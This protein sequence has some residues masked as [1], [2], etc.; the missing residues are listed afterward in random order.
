LS[1][2][3]RYGTGFSNYKKNPYQAIRQLHPAN[4]FAHFPDDI[5]NMPFSGFDA[6]SVEIYFGYGGK[7]VGN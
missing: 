4:F 2:K 7:R 5:C 1:S 3:N 6:I